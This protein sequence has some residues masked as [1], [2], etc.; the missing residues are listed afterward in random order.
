MEG[1][2]AL[3]KQ[4]VTP[5]QLVNSNFNK[6]SVYYVIVRLQSI[7][8]HVSLQSALHSCF[9]KNKNHFCTLPRKLLFTQATYW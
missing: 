3:K 7:V 4:K 5:L 8:P 1:V 6:S 2:F 9:Y